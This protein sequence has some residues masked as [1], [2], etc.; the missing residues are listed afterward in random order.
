MILEVMS[1]EHQS[2]RYY[3]TVLYSEGLAWLHTSDSNIRIRI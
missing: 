2:A 1:I 3:N